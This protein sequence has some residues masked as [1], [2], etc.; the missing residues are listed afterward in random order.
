VA[1]VVGLLIGLAGGYAALLFW[2]LLRHERRLTRM[3]R[4]YAADQAQSLRR[5]IH[6]LQQERDAL[7][8]E[9]ERLR[10]ER[11]ALVSQPSVAASP[12]AASPDPGGPSRW[13]G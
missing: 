9:V 6:E 11:E 7:A 13:L 2:A 10:A 1:A 4:S 8:Q 5:M 3:Q 12:Q